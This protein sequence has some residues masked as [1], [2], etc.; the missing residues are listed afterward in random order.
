MKF[1]ITP[2]SNSKQSYHQNSAQFAFH[3]SPMA[4]AR[5]KQSSEEIA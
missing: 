4:S 2:K 1:I 5:L 3:L